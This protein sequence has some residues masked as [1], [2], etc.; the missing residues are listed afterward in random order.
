VAAVCDPARP[1]RWV[2]RV[3]LTGVVAAGLLLATGLVVAV[4]GGRPRP[5][6]P[7]ASVHTLPARL[8][9]GDGVALIELGV[10]VLVLTP[11]VRV[12]VLAAG[13]ALAGEC[14]SAAVAVAVLALLGLSVWLGLG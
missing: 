5:V 4:A 1:T 3:L 14:R 7:P 9:A 6:G 12:S 2:H 10:L 13:W 8:A 11:A